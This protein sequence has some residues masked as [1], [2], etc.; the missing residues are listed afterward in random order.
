[1][2]EY[3]YDIA[4][5]LCKQDIEFARK[6]VKS[7]NPSL[8]VFFYEERQEELITTSGPET[9]AKV[10]KDESRI[11]VILSRNEWSETY[12]TDIERNAI[13]A[14]TSVQNE[15]Y[16]SIMII[17]MEQNE[18]PIWYPS[19]HIYVDPKRFTIEEIAKFVEF[20]VNEK[21]GIIKP[22]TVEDRYHNL[23]DRIEEKKRII[24]LQQS[25]E[26]IEAA[27]KEIIL[28][29]DCFNQ[30]CK[31]FINRSII[32]KTTF[33]EF[34]EFRNEAYFTLGE[35]KLECNII[36]PDE[37][38]QRILTTQ[39][40]CVSIELFKL[41]D[42]SKKSL[43][44]EERLFYYNSLLK[45]WSLKYIHKQLTDKELIVLFRDQHRTQYYDL[46][47]PIHTNS[48][49]DNWFQKLLTHSSEPIDQYL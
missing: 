38:Y 4:I 46:T 35:Y 32:G 7:L 2:K 1:M 21:G 11:I 39:D 6:L 8:N 29:K 17:P 15:G 48:L 12:Y 20:K 31:V 18:I 5:S 27:Q 45:G 3:T 25:T 30:K 47:K 14:R 44:K 28:L 33:Y 10:F 37:K 34:S 49:I 24:Q 16:S 36:L 40:F 41:Y 43:G 13:I 9:F 26:A 19:T 42:Q 22:I 23:L